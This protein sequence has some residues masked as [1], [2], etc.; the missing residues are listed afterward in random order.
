MS[1]IEE[2]FWVD[3]DAHIIANRSV[4]T[5][6]GVFKLMPSAN[7]ILPSDAPPTSPR[8][9]TS[10]WTGVLDTIAAAKSAADCQE[11]QLRDQAAAHEALSRELKLAH[12]K[13]QALEVLVNDVR[14]Q[15]EKKQQKMMAEAQSLRQEIE[16]KADA[17]LHTVE[18]RV[19]AAELRANVAEDWLKRIEQASKNLLPDE[20]RA[21][22]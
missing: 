10:D 9:V 19:R 1:T 16:A 12:H 6:S 13:I 11:N 21:A 7:T 15:A 17:R 8:Q 5:S 2:S 3:L 18:E 20:R 14:E 22:A 4:V